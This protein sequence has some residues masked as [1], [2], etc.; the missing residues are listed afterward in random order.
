MSTSAAGTANAMNIVFRIV[1]IVV[2]QN[3]SD[4]PNIYEKVC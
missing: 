1:R 3:V 4:I 2:V